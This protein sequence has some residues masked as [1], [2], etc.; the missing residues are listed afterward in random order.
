MVVFQTNEKIDNTRSCHGADG[1]VLVREVGEDHLR[2]SGY[3]TCVADYESERL[4][5][6]REESDHFI[7]YDAAGS[8]DGDH[9][10]PSLA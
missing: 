5:P 3:R 8:E 1:L 6:R 4:L 7:G 10:R 9:V 2:S